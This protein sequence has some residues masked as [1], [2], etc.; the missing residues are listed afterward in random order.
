[1]RNFVFTTKRFI[2]EHASA[3]F[4]HTPCLLNLQL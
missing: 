1:L 3:S 2:D 4:T